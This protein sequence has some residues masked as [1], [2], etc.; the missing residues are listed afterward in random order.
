M[1]WN[2]A[3]DKTEES[4]ETM[5]C[6]SPIEIERTGMLEVMVRFPDRWLGYSHDKSAKRRELAKKLRDLGHPRTASIS[7]MVNNI[8]TIVFVRIDDDYSPQNEEALN[9]ITQRVIR[10][11]L[12]YF[13]ESQGD[14]YEREEDGY[15]KRIFFPD[16]FKKVFQSIGIQSTQDFEK[17]TREELCELPGMR[18]N[19][20]LVLELGLVPCG[21]F[22]KPSPLPPYER[23]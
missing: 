2:G 5:H 19:D 17:I 23:G 3:K 9:N 1:R 21:I 7:T 15:V 11:A 4:G 8:A 16:R 12:M 13:G 18:T 20:V 14:I 10:T 22:L 6:K